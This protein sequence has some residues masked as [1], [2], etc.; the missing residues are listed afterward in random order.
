MR[1]LILG[2]GRMAE[3]HA[4]AFAAIEGVTL[5]ACVDVDVAR[6]ALSVLERAQ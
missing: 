3:A 5:A 6:A 4:T 1:L 2:T